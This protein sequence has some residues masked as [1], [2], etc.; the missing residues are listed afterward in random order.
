MKRGIFSH[1][2]HHK[3]FVSVAFSETGSVKGVSL[4]VMWC[5]FFVSTVVAL[6]YGLSSWIGYHQ[7]LKL[8]SVDVPSPRYKEQ[9][10]RLSS[11]RET[12]DKQIRVFAH[13]L[14]VL[15]ARLDRFDAIAERLFS[16][17][18]MGSH[19]EDVPELDAQGGPNILEE[20]EEVKINELQDSIS[21]LREKTDKVEVLMQSG[22]Q[23]LASKELSNDQK[24]S[25]WPAIHKNTRLS[26]TYGYRHD[27]FGKKKGWHGGIDLTG[28]YN[29][30]I[31]SAADGIVVFSGYRYNYGILVEI[32]HANG[33]STRYAHL[34]EATVQNGQQVKAGALI[35]LMGS[36]G[37][38]TGPHLHF[39]VLVGD[40]KV[41][42]LP[43][44]RG[45]QAAAREIAGRHQ[46][47]DLVA[48]LKQV[49][50]EMSQAH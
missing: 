33:F 21:L 44:V 20:D 23:L 5:I 9:I 25:V 15:Q 49:G 18:D 19:L 27:P 35:G 7:E 2:W 48:T 17:P 10:Q 50:L 39:E 31:V 13:E 8:A 34:N 11:E 32:R 47:K 45:G 14:G 43:F 12:Q 38:S 28:G 4:R 37:R 6:S 1:I 30:P 26:S 3:I 41:D 46:G 29:T 40:A 16:D 22:M 42:P 24:P 36:T